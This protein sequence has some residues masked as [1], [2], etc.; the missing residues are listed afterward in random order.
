MRA[1]GISDDDGYG[2]AVDSSGNSYGI[3]RYNSAS[4]VFSALPS[5]TNA[6]DYEVFVFKANP[7]GDHILYEHVQVYVFV[8]SI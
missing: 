1:G 6:G 3:G 8:L 7:T 5:L 2:V 4:M